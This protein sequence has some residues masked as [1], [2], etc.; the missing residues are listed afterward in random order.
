MQPPPSRGDP[1][2]T[3]P[4]LTA[5]MWQT[6]GTERRM[7]GAFKRDS[8][9]KGRKTPTENQ[10]VGGSLSMLKTAPLGGVHQQ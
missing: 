7:S 4:V 2:E 6:E 3:H 9:A 1:W 5:Q 10:R 8:L